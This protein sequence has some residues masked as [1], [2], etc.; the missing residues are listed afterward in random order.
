MYRSGSG[1]TH[2][3][4]GIVIQKVPHGCENKPSDVDILNKIAKRDRKRPLDITPVEIL[5][6]SAGK[7]TSPG[8]VIINE[9][10]Y[11]FLIGSQDISI[12]KDFAWHRCRQPVDISLFQFKE[13]Q[14]R[15]PGWTGF[16]R[17]VCKQDS[18]RKLL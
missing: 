3:T 15:I 8:R 4:N 12:R 7:R 2:C 17:V 5:P 13:E 14:Q 6:H 16:N 11:D 9:G 10:T 18:P 1:T